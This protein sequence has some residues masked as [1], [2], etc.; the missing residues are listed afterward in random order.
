MSL[1]TLLRHQM[2]VNRQF[3]VQFVSIVVASH[4]LFIL[5]T[6]LLDQISIRHSARLSALVIDLP[7][8]IGIS[9]LYL[10][11]LLRRRKQ[12]AWLVTVLAYS[13]Y[14][15]LGIANLITINEVHLLTGI[16]IIRGIV[17]P[18]AILVLLFT[19]QNDFIV[20]SDIQG[21][22][23]AVQFTCIMLLV[24][25]AYGVAGFSLLDRSDFHQEISF[26]SAIHYTID[27]FDLTTNKPLHPYTRRAKLFVNS[28]S[29]LSIGVAV[30]VVLS[31]FQ[32]L[33]FRLSD[34]SANRNQLLSI[35]MRYGGSSEDYFK[36]WPHDKQYFFNDLQNCAIAFHV[37]H[38]VALCL[39]DIV[40]EERHMN[41]LLSNFRSLCF[42]NDW[43]PSFIHIEYNNHALFEKHGFNLQKIGQEAVLDL[44]HFHDTVK[45]NKY[46]RNIQNKF[47]KQDYSTALLFPPH[48]KAIIDRL[49][50]ISNDWLSVGGRIERGFAMGYFTEEY[51]QQCQVMVV[52]DAAGTIQAFMNKLPTEYESEEVNFD[53]L[54]HTKNSPGNINDFLLMHFIS[55]MKQAGYKRLN[56]GLCPLVGLNETDAEKK[57]IIDGILRFAYANGDRFYSFSGLYRFKSKYEPEWR[58]RYI[59][60]QSGIRGFTRTANALMRCMRVKHSR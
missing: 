45:N 37:Y 58:D 30:Y 53:L 27:Q 54:R 6:S 36:L 4:G 56:L 17:L 14:L 26:P 39:G 8:L 28:L 2:R 1:N 55:A 13:L 40:G 10:S 59:A 34:Q 47:V 57:G 31:L 5:A 23:V 24:A 21:F 46:F 29:L 32:P 3:G 9:L 11:T 52:R 60:Y 51:M 22:R 15:G 41:Q 16:E 25:L 49:S 44:A 42:N 7:I 33:R 43:L 12:R 19:L 50:A 48:H 20:H 35:L 18:V 38:G